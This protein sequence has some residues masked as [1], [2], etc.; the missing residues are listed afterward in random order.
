MEVP[1]AKQSWVPEGSLAGSFARHHLALQ[2]VCAADFSCKLTCGAGPVRG[3]IRPKIQGEAGQKTPA[4]D[5]QQ[6]PRNRSEKPIRVVEK[7]WEPS[8]PAA[9]IA[10]ARGRTDRQK[11]IAPGGWL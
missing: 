9:R 1:R 5:C 3:R 11:N 4:K 8:N 2:V 10:G 7:A 6:K